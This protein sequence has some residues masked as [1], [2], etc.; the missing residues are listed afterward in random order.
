MKFNKSAAV[1]IKKKKRVKSKSLTHKKVKQFSSCIS[2]MHAYCR[3]E[4]RQREAV[5]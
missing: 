5:L 4:C 3:K 2:D 1:E